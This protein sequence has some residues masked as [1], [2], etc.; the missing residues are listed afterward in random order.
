[1]PGLDSLPPD[2]LRWQCDP[3]QFSFETSDELAVLEDIIGQERAVEA[4]EFGIGIRGKGYNLFALGPM[5]TGKHEIVRHFLSQKTAEQPTPPDVC[6]VHNFERERQPH[7]LLLPAGRG[8][9]LSD[10]IDHLIEDLKAAIPAAFEGEDYQT[11][12]SAINQEFLHHQEE[13]LSELE[14]RAEA[15]GVGLVRAP[16]GIGFAPLKGGEPLEPEENRGALRRGARADRRDHRGA[17]GDLPKGAAERA[18]LGAHPPRAAQDASRGGRPHRR[19]RAHRRA[20]RQLRRRPRRRRAPGQARRR[21]R[22]ERRVFRARPAR[23]A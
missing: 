16:Q 3:A 23:R 12:H 7:K 20:M 21:H 10:D 15:Q 17:R 18:A 11:R 6:Y 14:E 2:A 19:A 13:V 4:I 8:R 1:M 5:G 22:R 9:E